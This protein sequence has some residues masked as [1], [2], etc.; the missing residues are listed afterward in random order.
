MNSTIVPVWLKFLSDPGH[1]LNGHQSL[2]PFCPQH[3][4]WGMSE[5]RAGSWCSGR[6]CAACH[7]RVCICLGTTG[8]KCLTAGKQEGAVKV[9]S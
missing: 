5:F 1:S 7:M 4:L 2:S 3:T 9:R 8:E 6:Q